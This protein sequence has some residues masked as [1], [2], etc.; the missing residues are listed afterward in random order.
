M[1]VRCFFSVLCVC[2][3]VRVRAYVCVCV[4]LRICV[5]VQAS[6]HSCI[7]CLCVCV[8]VCLCVCELRETDRQRDRERESTVWFSV[9]HNI[10]VTSVP[11][12][13]VS[14]CVYHKLVTIKA[15]N[16]HNLAGA[17]QMKRQGKN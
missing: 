8:C 15:C 9:Y 3:C 2:V 11:V 4:Y 6:V 12:Q 1:S 5:C 14:L 10:Y 16:E 7:M 17:S 13:F